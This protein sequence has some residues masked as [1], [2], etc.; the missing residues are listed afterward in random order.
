MEVRLKN[1]KFEKAI[2]PPK[3]LVDKGLAETNVFK[4]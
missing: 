2:I 1:G 3:M 4:F